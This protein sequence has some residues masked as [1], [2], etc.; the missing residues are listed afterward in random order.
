VPINFFS[1]I[2]SSPKIEPATD[3]VSPIVTATLTILLLNCD[4]PIVNFVTVHSHW[5]ARPAPFKSAL[6]PFPPTG[7]VL[8]FP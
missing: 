2:S 8:Y 3:N 5:H 4:D 7:F 1:F 6:P